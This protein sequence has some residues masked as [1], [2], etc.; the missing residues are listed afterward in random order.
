MMGL[1]SGEEVVLKTLQ[2]PLAKMATMMISMVGV[3][4]NTLGQKQIQIQ[5]KG[6]VKG[7]VK[8]GTLVLPM[9]FEI[10]GQDEGMP[11]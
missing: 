9:P 1:H 4:N 6:E 2:M 7:E 5:M 8:A 11:M 10:C 3:G